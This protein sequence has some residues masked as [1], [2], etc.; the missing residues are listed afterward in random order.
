[1]VFK[2]EN[3]YKILKKIWEYGIP[4]LEFLWAG[5]IEIWPIPYGSQIL[6]TIGVVWGALAIFLGISKMRYNKEKLNGDIIDHIAQQVI[7]NN[8]TEEEPE[9]EAK[10]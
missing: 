10:G 8:D 3:I 2:N 9:E 5:L 7:T 1:M 4:A 6:A